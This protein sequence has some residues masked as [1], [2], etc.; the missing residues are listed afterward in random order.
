M[1]VSKRYARPYA[2]PSNPKPGYIITNSNDDELMRVKRD[3]IRGY[4]AGQYTYPQISLG[5]Y[6]GAGV[7]MPIGSHSLRLT[8]NYTHAKA[9]ETKITSNLLSVNAGIAF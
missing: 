7:E 9:G 8:A 4:Y 5:F 2:R 1:P 6:V 3:H